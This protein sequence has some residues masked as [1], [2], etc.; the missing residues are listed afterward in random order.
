VPPKGKVSSAR[1]INQNSIPIK[2]TDGKEKNAT[3]VK[4]KAEATH[5]NV[6]AVSVVHA[7][8]IKIVDPKGRHSV[9]VHEYI[10][11][12][13]ILNINICIYLYVHIYMYMLICIYVCI[14]IRILI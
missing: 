5:G 1:T 9:L 6:A 8:T 2:K 3:I 14:Y 4:D 7:D 13:M 10:I 12:N 11:M